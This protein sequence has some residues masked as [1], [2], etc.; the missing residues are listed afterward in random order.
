MANAVLS[1]TY[2]C[3]IQLGERILSKDDHLLHRENPE[4]TDVLLGVSA[5]KL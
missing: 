4:N 1:A 2:V 5:V 3:L